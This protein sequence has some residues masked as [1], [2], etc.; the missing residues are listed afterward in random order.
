MRASSKDII[1]KV[2][3]TAHHR[4][5]TLTK[6]HVGNALAGMPVLVLTTTGRRSGQPRQTMLTSPVRDGE[7]IVLVAS[8]GG[9]DRHPQWFLNLLDDPN[10]SVT[11]GG[12]SRSMRARV[13][14]AE[15]KARLWPEVTSAYT[16]YA[17]YQRRTN[18][19]IPLVLL[20]PQHGT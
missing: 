3:T 9:D 8:Y 19:D 10:V 2:L 6:G 12:T 11:M 1:A 18:R 4:L 16:G 5:F 7:R 13:A 15:E 17:A 20:D 14:T